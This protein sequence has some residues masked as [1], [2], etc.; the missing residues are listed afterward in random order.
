MDITSANSTLIIGITGLYPVPQQLAGFAQDDAYSMADVTNAEV[1]MGVDAIMS[2]GWIPQI[3]EMGVSLQADSLSNTF[4]EAWYAAEEAAKSKFFAFA[5][6][7]QPSV[8]KVYALLNGVLSGY[9]P[10]ADA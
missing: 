7:Q 2:A 3:K 5:T 9:S 6:I 10:Y 4:F 1:L 8:G